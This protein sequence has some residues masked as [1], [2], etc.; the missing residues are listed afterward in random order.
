MIY[1]QTPIHNGLVRV[2]IKEDGDGAALTFIDTQWSVVLS[3][4]PLN[5][6]PLHLLCCPLCTH[7]ICCHSYFCSFKNVL[8]IKD[9]QQI[10]CQLVQVPMCNSR[11]T[12]RYS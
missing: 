10:F 9:S 11:S 4:P 3:V 12:Q 6:P 2:S 1:S 7:E 8:L 5:L